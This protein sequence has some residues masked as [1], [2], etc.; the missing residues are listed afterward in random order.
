MDYCGRT[1]TRTK[2]P[3]CENRQTQD[4]RQGEDDPTRRP[5]LASGRNGQ[6]SVLDLMCRPCCRQISSR[7]FWPFRSVACIDN[8]HFSNKAIATFWESLD[9]SRILR[10]VPQCTPELRDCDVDSLV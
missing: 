7:R 3:D 10:R 2:Y 4:K 9:I 6:P 1:A 5:S 8:R